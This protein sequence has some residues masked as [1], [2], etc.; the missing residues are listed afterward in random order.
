LVTY[1]QNRFTNAID[2][3]D[4]YRTPMPCEAR[5]Y[6]LTGYAPTGPAGRFQASDFV[7]PDPNDAKRLIHIFDGEIQYEQQPDGGKQRR[8]I[9]MARTLYR[10]ND[11][12]ATQNDPLA[13]L[14][15]GTLESLALNGDNYKLAFHTRTTG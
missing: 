14:L 11:M 5:T 15:L 8:L 3:D 4:D 12:G 2:L 6:E 13:L 7:K 10:P 1:T 9:E